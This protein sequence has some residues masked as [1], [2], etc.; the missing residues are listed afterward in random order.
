MSYF[1]TDK[2]LTYTFANRTSE[3]DLLTAHNN[4]T[5]NTSITFFTTARTVTGTAVLYYYL[6]SIT[7]YAYNIN[8]TNNKSS[9]ISKQLNVIIDPL[10]TNMVLTIIDNAN[11]SSTAIPS[12]AGS[13]RKT[14][15]DT[16]TVNAFSD[17]SAS[18]IAYDNTQSIAS[19]TNNYNNELQLLN[20]L[21][22]TKTNTQTGAYANYSN[23]GTNPINIGGPDYSGIVSTGYRWATFR[24][25][26]TNGTMSSLQLIINGITITPTRDTANKLLVGGSD[27]KLYYRIE[28]S[29]YSS[30][31]P[32]N[33]E[34][35]QD[36]ITGG[37]AISTIW[38]NAN[39]INNNTNFKQFMGVNSSSGTLGGISSINNVSISGT[40]VTYPLSC[41]SINLT[42][43][44]I[45]IYAMI[46]LPMN[47][48]V[49][50]SSL[51][52]STS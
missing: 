3:T 18:R 26:V 24:W 47:I 37:R 8:K 20:G 5:G 49:A 2:I 31:N 32:S 36:A 16:T 38:I 21:F 50:F 46:G 28:N 51:T 22:L 9:P 33:T 29:S 7:L 14:I 25:R 11:K 44:T 17:Y 19:T 27:L 13:R 34:Y 10:S 52:C 35:T 43:D 39:S 23:T 48:N 42:A 4:S 1:H 45:Y 40:T 41:P 15:T 12:I 6:P 30:G